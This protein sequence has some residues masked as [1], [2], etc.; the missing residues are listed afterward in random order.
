MSKGT[1]ERRKAQGLC[2]KCGKENSNGF[3][4]CDECMEKSKQYKKEWRRAY[5][6]LG[7]CPKCQ[8]N[9]VIRGQGLCVDCRDAH[10]ERG[11]TYRERTSSKLSRIEYQKKFIARKKAEGLCTKCGTR[12]TVGGKVWCPRCL[13]KNRERMA[14]KRLENGI[15]ERSLRLELGYCFQC[16]KPLDRDGKICSSCYATHHTPTPIANPYWIRSN[17][18]MF[19]EIERRRLKYA[20]N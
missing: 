16:G 3:V 20:N 14:K 6:D 10:N 18:A 12:K 4:M 9:P 13:A 19:E 15:L 17:T 2:V 8:T 11:K 5:L 1:Y 7:I